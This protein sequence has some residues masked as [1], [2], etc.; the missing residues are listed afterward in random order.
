[1][2]SQYV[3]HWLWIVVCVLLVCQHIFLSSLI[4]PTTPQFA[5]LVLY[6]LSYPGSQFCLRFVSIHHS[7]L[8]VVHTRLKLVLEILR[9]IAISSKSIPWQTCVDTAEIAICRQTR[10]H[11]PM[12]VI[13]TTTPACKLGDLPI[14]LPG[15]LFRRYVT[16][17]HS[18][19]I[20]PHIYQVSS[21]SH[22][23][24]KRSLLHEK[25]YADKPTRH[26]Q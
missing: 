15:K 26:R 5:R 18:E 8:N 21:E 16:I 22:K 10:I 19:L 11:L 17:H 6:Q 25:I 1:M 4:E 9:N 12:A 23:K 20:V 14:E 3:S 24:C 2:G 13:E 7:E